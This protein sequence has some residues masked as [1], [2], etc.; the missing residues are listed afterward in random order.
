MTSESICG[1]KDLEPED[2]EGCPMPIRQ[3]SKKA[4][5]FLD[6]PNWLFLE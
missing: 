6:W 2:T 3:E 4:G 5:Y 1:G